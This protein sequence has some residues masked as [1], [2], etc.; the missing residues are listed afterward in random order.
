MRELTVPRAGGITAALIDAW[1]G[2]DPHR[3]RLVW[4]GDGR[5]ELS[6]SSLVNW[7]AK[8]AG[9]LIDELGAAP[10]DPVLW[11]VHRSWQGLPLLLGCWWAGL[12]VVDGRPGPAAPAGAPVAAFVD[13]GDDA[14]DGT[15]ADEVV[16]ASPHPFGLA[17]AGL[18]PLQRNVAD[19]I[20]PQADRFVPRGPGPRPEDPAVVT[21]AGRLTV[22]EALG[23]ASRAALALGEAPVLL[24][25]RPPERPDD[26][27]RGPL[28]AWAAGGTFVV[29]ATAIDRV[30]ADERVTATLGVDVPGLPRVDR[31]G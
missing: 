15:E 8:T 23:A 5:T 25:A 20:L 14:G 2:A 24:S 27:V 12:V 10:G 22:G 16:V 29:A 9:Y 19:A 4:H 6:G 30:A 31:T 1:A 17:V 21:A 7:S 18:P 28:A 26:L 11:R 3:P 13:A